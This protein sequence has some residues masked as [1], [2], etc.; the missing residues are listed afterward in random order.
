MPFLRRIRRASPS[1]GFLK[2]VLYLQTG[3]AFEIADIAGDEDKGLCGG[4]GSD[5]PVRYGARLAGR[6]EPR[7]FAGQPLCGSGIEWK[8]RC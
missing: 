6:F 8:D 7:A 3:V 1:R 2:P 4:H 5:H